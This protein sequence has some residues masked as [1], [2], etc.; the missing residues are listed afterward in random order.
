MIF[1]NSPERSEV[2]V[3]SVINIQDKRHAELQELPLCSLSQHTKGK[4]SYCDL[5][6]VIAL[7][8]SQLIYIGMSAG[9]L[10]GF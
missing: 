7:T 6:P 1:L 8:H 10:Q 2:A 4:V 5:Y 9:P 3:R